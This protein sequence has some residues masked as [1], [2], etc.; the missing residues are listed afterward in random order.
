[1]PMT[2]QPLFLKSE[3]V[4]QFWRQFVK[5]TFR[6][7]FEWRE[8]LRQCFA[9]GNKSFFLVSF[10][11]FLAGIV[12][13]TQSRPSLSSFGAESWLPSLVAQAVVRSLGPLITGLICAGKLGS[14]IGAELASMKVTEQ[15]DAMDVSGSRPFSYLVVSRIIATTLML[16]ILVV[17]ADSI[18]LFG[19]YLTIHSMNN[20][21]FTSYVNAIAASITYIDIFSSLIKG[22]F[23]GFSIGFVSTYAGFNS[24]N[25]TTG[26]GKAANIAVVVSMLSIFI[27]DLLMLQFLKL[28]R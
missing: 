23:I 28:I 1:M 7:R 26:V 15:I 18:A 8:I 20:T 17:Y 14:N 19:S 4:F 22:I 5:E 3:S 16:P 2:F 13:T 6:G 25:G 21:G 12:F 11:A 24:E 10:T 9:V 27:V